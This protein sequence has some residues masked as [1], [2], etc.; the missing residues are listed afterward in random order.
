MLADF[1]SQNGQG[2]FTIRVVNHVSNFYNSA[3][4]AKKLTS[5]WEKE[6]SILLDNLFVL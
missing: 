6:N 4:K 1:F 2:V 3:K 5:N